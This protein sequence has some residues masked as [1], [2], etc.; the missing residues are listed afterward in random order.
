MMSN[1]YVRIN[2]TTQGFGQ[3]IPKEDI[4]KYIDN[5]DISWYRS[6]YD[7]DNEALEYTKNNNGS[8]S[9]F[10]GKAFTNKL[11]FDFDSKVDIQQAKNDTINL[12]VKLKEMGIDINKSVQVFF[13]GNKGYHL[14]LYTNKKYSPEE[15]KNI[16]KE[17]AHGLKTFDPVI[18]N[19][20][21]LYRLQNTKHQESGL[22]KIELE[23]SELE[24]LTIDEIKQLAKT[25]RQLNFT[26]EAFTNTEVFDKY[27]FEKKEVKKSSIITT[28]ELHAIRGLDDIDFSK[29][30]KATPRCIHALMNGVALPGERSRVFFRLATFLRNS[31]FNKD[32]AYSTLKGVARINNELYPEFE[33]IGKSEI[34]NQH[35]ASVYSEKSLEELSVGGFGTSPDNELIKKY[36]DHIK[37]AKPCIL[38]GKKDQKSLITVEET[39]NKFSVFAENF[40]K[41]LIQT[42]IQAIDS[43]M[44]LT[45]GTMSILA[46]ACGTGKSSMALS[47]LKNANEFGYRSIF[48]SMDMPLSVNYL[49][50]AT[51]VTKYTQDEIL[52]AFRDRNKKITEEISLKVGE[53]FNLT[54]FDFGSTQTLEDIRD[55]INEVEQQTGEKIKFAVVD[56]FSR[57]TSPY[58]DE[59]T[60][61]NYLALKSV[62][63]ANNSDVAFLYLAQ[64]A[65]AGGNGSTPIRSSRVS[66]SSGMIEEAAHN[67]VTI[68]R[69]FMGNKVN[70]NYLRMYL[71]KNRL[72]S[73]SEHLLSWNGEKGL[74]KDLNEQEYTHYEQNLASIEEE[75]QPKAFSF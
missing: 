28:N 27:K 1:S 10:K 50:M 24:S 51:L 56:Y 68:W 45:V 2:K 20:T 15:T 7:Y 74:V 43:N 36:C 21:R 52:H 26:P 69:P 63:L 16:C 71:A 22:F 8:I 13:S 34:W 31:G 5:N 19:T 3:L 53:A 55:K 64:V 6:L 39:T 25:P 47:I 41:N 33:P 62:E 18:Y 70:D 42:G 14:E 30:P 11:I 72:G 49:K 38:H 17:L 58:S 44:K 60:S 59:H 54:T 12:L 48:F 61:A 73:I 35:I 23:P 29:C 32:V 4:Q 65:R 66:R 37:T 46:A 9:G 57:L 40:E 75:N 67:V